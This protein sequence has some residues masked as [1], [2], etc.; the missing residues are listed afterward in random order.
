MSQTAYNERWRQDH[1]KKRNKLLVPDPWTD[2]ASKKSG[3]VSNYICDAICDLA[4][5]SA[6][7]DISTKLTCQNPMFT[8]CV[9]LIND[10]LKM[11]TSETPDAKTLK[12][13][14]LA[15]LITTH[16]GRELHV[17]PNRWGSNSEFTADIRVMDTIDGAMHWLSLYR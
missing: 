17:P 11:E 14:E 7:Q 15:T 9:R 12:Y 13:N 10:Y 16:L 4:N 6:E 5:I 1:T 2:K 3:L 8:E